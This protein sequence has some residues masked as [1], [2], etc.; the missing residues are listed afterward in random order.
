MVMTEYETK[1]LDL[2]KDIKKLLKGT[3]V[4]EEKA[5]EILNKIEL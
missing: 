2:L 3:Y 4:Q 1:S 5:N